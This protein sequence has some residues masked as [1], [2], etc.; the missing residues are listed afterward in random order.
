MDYLVREGF[1]EAAKRFA[2]EA[3]IQQVPGE[4]EHIDERVAIRNAI[5]AGDIQTAIEHI[6]DI[7]P[8]VSC[9]PFPSR[10]TPFCND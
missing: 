2:D 6:N 7:N 1:P 8:D 3:N 10:D 5:L 4:T 9:P